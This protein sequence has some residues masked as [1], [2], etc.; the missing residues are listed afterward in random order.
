M[1]NKQFTYVMVTQ[2]CVRVTMFLNL[3]TAIL[4]KVQNKGTKYT[5]TDF[6]KIGVYC[7]AWAIGGL[8]E[9]EEREKI[10]KVLETINPSIMP[11]I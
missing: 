5:K 4:K 11:N 1:L 6:D 9:T 2:P 10:H 3:I 8:F 7:F